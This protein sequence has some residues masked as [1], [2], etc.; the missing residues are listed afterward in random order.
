MM[1]FATCLLGLCVAVCL[2]SGQT[3]YGDAGDAVIYDSSLLD[4]L[5]YSGSPLASGGYW[6]ANFGT[7]A[8]ETGQP[9]DQ[10]EV[11]T[12]PSWFGLDSNPANIGTTYSWADD[13]DPNDLSDDEIYDGYIAPLESR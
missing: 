13:E 10:N 7:A 12:L 2:L 11:N 1:R 3:V 4:T 5:N 6:F 8:P 9:V